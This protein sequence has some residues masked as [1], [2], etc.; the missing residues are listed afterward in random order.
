M[1]SNLIIVIALLSFFLPT[2]IAISSNNAGGIAIYW[3]QRGDE[4]TLEETCASGNYAFVNI[5]FLSAFGNGT[6]PVLNLAGHCDAHTGQ[7]TVLSSDIKSCQAKN[8]KVMLSIG[9]ATFQNYTLTSSVDAGQVAAYLW[10]NFLGGQ[11]SLRPL[12]DAVL[13]GIDFVIEGGQYH[14]WDDLAKNLS[15]YNNQSKKVYLTAAPQCPFPDTC[16]GTA[17]STGLFDYVWVQFYNNH[18]C[19]YN[20]GNITGLQ[21]YWGIWTS[22]IHADMI[23]LGLPAAINA[24]I[25]G[26]IPPANLTSEV[27]PIVKNSTK[28]GGV[29]LWSRYWD[30]LTNYSSFIKSYV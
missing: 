24:S 13:D 11:S 29:M 25:T 2:I 14:Y 30:K 5:A 8:I 20:K 27:L 7:C 1:A 22:N 12:G 18:Q 3:G 9:G 23:F 19:E 10:N 16:L 21:D 17:L 26:F 28:Y 4:G 15:S 6:N